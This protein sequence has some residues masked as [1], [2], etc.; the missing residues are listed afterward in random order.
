MLD[1]LLPQRCL[2][3]GASGTQ[4]C[5][6]CRQDLPSL[7]SPL[8]ARCGAPTA[9]PVRRCRECEGRR[10]LFATARAAVPYDGDARMLVAAWKERGLRRFADE[11]ARLVAER[12]PRPPGTTVTF[13]PAD[14]GRS[15]ARGHHP[16]ARLAGAL[17]ERWD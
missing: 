15:R 4:L 10:L 13:V 8:C 1:L 2:L 6:A 12:V 17:A 9:W 7:P 5:A 14:D 16:A 11:A 3:C